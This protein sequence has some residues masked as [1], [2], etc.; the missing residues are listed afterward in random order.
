MTRFFFRI[1]CALVVA[2]A[3]SPAGAEGLETATAET[4][5][6]LIVGPMEATIENYVDG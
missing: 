3:V 6:L 5:Q 1:A 4:S 2:A